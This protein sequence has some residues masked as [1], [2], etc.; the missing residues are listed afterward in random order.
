M[1]KLWN[2]LVVDH[3]DPKT[4]VAQ[5]IFPELC[6][7]S[8]TSVDYLDENIKEAV[9]SLFGSDPPSTKSASEVAST[10]NEIWNMASPTAYVFSKHQDLKFYCSNFEKLSQDDVCLQTV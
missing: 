3:P 9:D 1:T 8:S 4:L 2:P 6:Q 5:D 10:S 7:S